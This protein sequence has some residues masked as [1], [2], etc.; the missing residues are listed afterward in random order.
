MTDLFVSAPHN[1]SY[2]ELQVESTF[3]LFLCG[4]MD[5][6]ANV[7][8]SA[9]SCFLVKCCGPRSLSPLTAASTG[10]SGDDDTLALTEN[11]CSI[12]RNLSCTHKSELDRR[13]CII[14]QAAKSDLVFLQESFVSGAKGGTV[15]LFSSCRLLRF[16]ILFSSGEVETRVGEE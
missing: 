9:H 13:P 10:S 3:Q 4:L 1:S 15:E 14:L 11:E 7:L 12:M 6:S 8:T 16:A 5:C 2:F